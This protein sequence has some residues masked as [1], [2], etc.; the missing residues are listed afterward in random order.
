M[1]VRRRTSCAL[2]SRRSPTISTATTRCVGRVGVEGRPCRRVVAPG[3]HCVPG[4]RR[5]YR[6]P[7]LPGAAREGGRTGGNGGR[8]GAS[9]EGVEGK[10][11]LSNVLQLSTPGVSSGEKGPGVGGQ[12]EGEFAVLATAARGGELVQRAVSSGTLKCKGAVDGSA[13]RTNG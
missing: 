11:K 13:K 10:G 8:A 5:L 1:T 7:P 9:R 6:K 4:A 2:C 3:A 12:E